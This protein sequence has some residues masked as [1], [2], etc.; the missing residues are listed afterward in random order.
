M[1]RWRGW[2]DRPRALAAIAA[3][4]VTAA[5]GAALTGCGTLVANLTEETASN[6]SIQ[7]INN[8]PFRAALTLGTFNDLDRRPPGNVAFEQLR[9][10][11]NTSSAVRNLDCMRDV[12]IG[13]RKLLDRIL[14]TG[15]DEQANFDP[16][17]FT[18]GVNFSTAPADS[19]GA[20]LPDA[21]K[22]PPIVVRLGVDYSCNDLLL[23]TL[24][25]A[26]DGTFTIDYALIPDASA[27][28]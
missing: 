9:L 21:G 24:N 13:T 19:P 10:E 28:E 15:G 4:A 1:T 25:Q 22:A 5:T 26:D 12:A 6:V 7:V 16:D 11:A 23:F 20:A 8:T 18:L 3:I 27:D 2:A 14:D 17:A